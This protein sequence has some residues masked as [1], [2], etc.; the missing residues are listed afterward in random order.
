MITDTS[1]VFYYKHEGC[2]GLNYKP[3]IIAF[4][5]IKPEPQDSKENLSLLY[6]IFRESLSQ[7]KAFSHHLESHGLLPGQQLIIYRKYLQM[8]KIL[9]AS[10]FQRRIREPA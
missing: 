5:D 7:P 2:R 8:K 6:K 9:F 1:R 3:V 4:L 10:V